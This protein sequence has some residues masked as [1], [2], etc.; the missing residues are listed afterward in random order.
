MD[1]VG[2]ARLTDFGLSSVFT[3]SGAGGSITD[4]HAVRWAAPEVL[5]KERPVSTKSDVY[6]FSMVI[7]EVRAERYFP[8]NWIAQICQGIHREGTVLWYS[9]YNSC[10]RYF[11][12]KQTFPTDASRY[13]QRFLEDRGPLLGSG[14]ATSPRY[15]GSGSMFAKLDKPPA[16]SHRRER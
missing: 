13:Y 5:D 9:A 8:V 7:I 10:G 4:G 3:G 11:G 12:G 1:D 15:L 16:R 2:H 14:S 6:S